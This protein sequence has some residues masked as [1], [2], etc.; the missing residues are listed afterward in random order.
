[1]NRHEKSG[2]NTVQL[3]TNRIENPPSRRL[4]CSR[5]GMEFSCGLGGPC[6]CAEENVRLPMP[7]DTGEDCLCRE[8][9]RKA[10]AQIS[11]T[12]VS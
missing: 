11:S 2:R 6:W 8:C 4:A 7:G 1:M 10:A 5:C 3:M 9:L 12:P